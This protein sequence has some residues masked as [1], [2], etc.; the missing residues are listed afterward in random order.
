MHYPIGVSLG[1]PYCTEHRN[2]PWVTLVS[3]VGFLSIRMSVESLIGVSHIP[4]LCLSSCFVTG[5]CTSTAT[6]IGTSG[7]RMGRNRLEV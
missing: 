7:S 4:L 1:V 2:S 5:R 6:V 3:A